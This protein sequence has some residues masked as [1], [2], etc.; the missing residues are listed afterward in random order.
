[1]FPALLM[2][3]P[4][5]QKAATTSLERV[6]GAQRTRR[7]PLAVRA[8]SCVRS[9]PSW[10]YVLRVEGQP[11]QQAGRALLEQGRRRRGREGHSHEG[12]WPLVTLYSDTRSRQTS[13][14]GVRHREAC[15][16]SGYRGEVLG[17]TGSWLL[18]TRERKV[19]EGGLRGSLPPRTLSCPWRP[20]WSAAHLQKEDGGSARRGHPASRRSPLP[21]TGCL[22]SEKPKSAASR[23]QTPSSTQLALRA[24]GTQGTGAHSVKD[25]THKSFNTGKSQAGNKP[26]VLKSKYLTPSW[27][28]RRV[29]SNLREQPWA[30]V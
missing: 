19:A 1:M 17:A 22:V 27:F 9:L 13:R 4:R 20:A 6:P 23:P 16:H 21:E 12:R 7:F 2:P 28:N 10:P 25:C 11:G 29:S 5:P 24:S 30:G 14:A 26:S 15:H 3:P 8:P 18:T